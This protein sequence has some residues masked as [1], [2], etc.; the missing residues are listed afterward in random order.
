MR[1]KEEEG[2]ERGKDGGEKEAASCCC[3]MSRARWY[4]VCEVSDKKEN[5]DGAC[6]PSCSCCF[7]RCDIFFPTP[8]EIIEFLGSPSKGVDRRR[9]P[10]RGCEESGTYNQI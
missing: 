7:L 6:T 4:S 9:K 5:L 3:L 8:V 2:G 1:L 10:S